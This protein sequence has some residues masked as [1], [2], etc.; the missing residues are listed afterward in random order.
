MSTTTKLKLSTYRN[1]HGHTFK[2]VELDGVLVT[3]PQKDM[4]KSRNWTS[5]ARVY[6][7]VDVLA[8]D[9][10]LLEP[11][12]V[13]YT[14]ENSTDV[15]RVKEKIWLTW[16]DSMK[17]I[18]GQRLSV[19]LQRLVEADIEDVSFSDDLLDKVTFSFK[20]GCSCGCSPGFVLNG[21]VRSGVWNS[22]ISLT[23]LS[24]GIEKVED[25]G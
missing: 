7:A 17:K 9:I 24:D 6:G 14:D 3:F 18:A 22:D 20:A 19:L 10:D 4:T 25:E 5:K 21:R 8:K 12:Y 1:K 2:A 23:T 16:R 13:A 15:E 11:D